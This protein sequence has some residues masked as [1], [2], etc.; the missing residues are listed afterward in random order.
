MPFLRRVIGM[1]M[2]EFI[3]TFALVSI[4]VGSIMAAN[5][6]GGGLLTIALAHGLTIAVMATALGHRSGGH[7]NPAVTWGALLSGQTRHSFWIVVTFIPV[8]V[9]GAIAGG[10]ALRVIFPSH[11][12]QSVQ[13]GIPQ[14]IHV[15][16][17]GAIIIEALLTALLVFAFLGTTVDGRAPKMGALFVGLMVTVGIL[18]A[19][20]FTGG[21]MNP[22]RALGP[23]FAASGILEGAWSHWSVYWIGPMGG[24]TVAAILYRVFIR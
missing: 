22:A 5:V 19:G 24:S 2:A 7:F 9:F 10:Y 21:A 1:Y 11:L 4:G 6:G 3:G 14:I 12:W 23:A 13:L 16:L 18:M 17:L 20:P 8:Q 15:S